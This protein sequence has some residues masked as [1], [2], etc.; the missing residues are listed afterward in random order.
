MLRQRSPPSLPSAWHSRPWPR[1]PRAPSSCPFL[2]QCPT[3]CCSWGGR[4][5]ARR[6]SFARWHAYC[7]VRVH[8][9]DG[10]G[11]ACACRWPPPRRLQP[12]R[13]PACNPTAAH[14]T[15]LKA[16][17]LMCHCPC[18]GAP[19]ACRRAAQARRHRGH[20]V[21]LVLFLFCSCP[22]FSRVSEHATLCHP[23]Q[24]RLAWHAAHPAACAPAALAPHA[25]PPAP[26]ARPRSNEIGG[27]GDV[28]HPAIGG[29]RR[30]QVP[31]PSQQHKIMVSAKQ[32]KKR[33]QT[34]LLAF[35]RPAGGA[36]RVHGGCLPPGRRAC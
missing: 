31:D 17:V 27:D 21:P 18:G 36:A 32:Q 10:L 11:E 2:P 28:P 5:W 1:C 16:L 22:C 6:P 30:M 7:R 8:V 33:R 20:Q 35:P 12:L 4:A 25:R 23:V 19:L 13:R 26:P 15:V 3:R 29:A 24:L 14:A 9:Q 34:W